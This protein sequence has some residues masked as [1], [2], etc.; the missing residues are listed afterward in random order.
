MTEIQP[1]SASLG[2]AS[3]ETEQNFSLR[4]PVVCFDQNDKGGSLTPPLPGV[5]G[6]N[7]RPQRSAALELDWA[8]HSS[9]LRLCD[10]AGF[11]QLLGEAFFFDGFCGFF[12]YILFGVAT[13]THRQSF[14]GSIGFRSLKTYILQSRP[15]VGTKGN[16]VK[17]KMG[18]MPDSTE[19]VPP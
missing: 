3:E 12:L 13:F 18:G 11:F 7:K 9:P 14:P 10:F 4:T 19:R 17:G 8:T 1:A 15:I 6:N 2:C 5:R 16:C